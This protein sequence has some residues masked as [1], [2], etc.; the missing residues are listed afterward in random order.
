VT[1]RRIFICWTAGLLLARPRGALAQAAKAGRIG[2]LAT[3]PRA[4][5]P[6][7]T[8]TLVARLAELGYVEGRNLVVD[9]R[10][11]EAEPQ[12]QA[13][14]LDLAQAGAQVIVAPNPYSLRA[15]RAAPRSVPIVG[16]DLE[17]DPVA[18]GYAASLARPGGNVTGVFLDQSEVSAKQLQLLKEIVPGL[19]KVAVLWDAPLATAQRE[20]VED[21]GRRLDVQILP[22]A[23]RGPEAL[24]EALRAAKQAGAHGLIV[25][26]SPLIERN[27]KSVAS[28]ALNARLPAIGLTGVFARDGLL[29]TYGPVQPDL[30]RAVG[31]L[32]AKILDG[33]R[34][35]ELPIER[36]V[37]FALVVNQA[38][39]RALGLAIPSV[40]LMRADKVI[41]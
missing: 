2:Y 19:S 23:W 13:I 31:T 30:H 20:A 37:H 4:S 22:V 28:V 10:H 33:A 29:V 3:S 35:A 17:S 24:P 1:G 14:A 5:I 15:A 8:A 18:A 6:M 40:V 25:L 16:Y 32:V 7:A 11:A 26:S 39:A 12:L 34:P 21:A 27:R 38:S 9:F 36:P 41:Q